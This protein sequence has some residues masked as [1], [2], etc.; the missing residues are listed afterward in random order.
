VP[1]TVAIV[2]TDDNPTNSCAEDI[3]RRELIAIVAIA[4]AS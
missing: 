4:I 3:M 2:A 1:K